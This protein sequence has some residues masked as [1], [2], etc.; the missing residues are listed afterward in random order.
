MLF[1]ALLSAADGIAEFTV[2]VGAVCC[3]L[4]SANIFNVATKLFGPFLAFGLNSCFLFAEDCA[5]AVEDNTL[6]LAAAEMDE[7]TVLVGAAHC[8]FFEMKLFDPFFEL[9]LK[10]SF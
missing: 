6:L 1:N 10:S 3:D 8:N 2:L 5:I 4:S 7:F 9:G